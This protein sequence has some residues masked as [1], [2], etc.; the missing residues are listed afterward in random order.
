M[1]ENSLWEVSLRMVSSTNAVSAHACVIQRPNSSKVFWFLVSVTS[2]EFRTYFEQ[3]GPLMDSIVLVD[4]NTGRSRGFGFVSFESAEDAKKLLMKAQPQGVENPNPTS[5]HLIMMNKTIEVKL[6]QPKES[7]RRSNSNNNNKKYTNT[8]VTYA[9]EVP[10]AAPFAAA[11]PIPAADPN[12]VQ[13]AYDYN[14]HPIY[15]PPHAAMYAYH[16][17]YMPPVPY[18]MPEGMPMHP[19]YQPAYYYPYPQ[20]APNMA[21]PPTGYPPENES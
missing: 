18:G 7:A 17:G 9:A 19:G 5:G 3:F 12:A 13:E 11:Y 4:R 6:A 8:P 2:E 1:N 20:Y 15:Y 16:Q 14:N 21:F 10:V